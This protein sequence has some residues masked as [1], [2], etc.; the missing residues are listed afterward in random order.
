[1]FSLWQ[2]G[3]GSACRYDCTISFSVI[4]LYDEGNIYEAQVWLDE[5][6]IRAE[7]ALRLRDSADN[8]Q[9][10]RQVVPVCKHRHGPCAAQVHGTQ[11]TTR[12]QDQPRHCGGETRDGY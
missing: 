6:G 4:F 8:L 10:F 9:P 11:R 5:E 3:L 7:R 1:M 2:A 12:E